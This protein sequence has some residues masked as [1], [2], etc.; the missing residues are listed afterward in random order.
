METFN[1]YYKV[2]AIIFM[3]LVWSSYLPATNGQLCSYIHTY[4]AI[5][6]HIYIF[7]ILITIHTNQMQIAK[8][9][10]ASLLASG[11]GMFLGLVAKPIYYSCTVEILIMSTMQP[12]SSYLIA[13]SITL[14]ANQIAIILMH[15][16]NH[17][18]DVD[19]NLLFY[20]YSTQFNINVSLTG[21]ASTSVILSSFS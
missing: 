12:A 13:I 4:I 11:V 17:L 21:I 16:F 9:L 20:N 14:L 18:L 15:Y 19:L 1:H 8:Q 3:D 6:I 2:V 7:I 5:Y 10:L